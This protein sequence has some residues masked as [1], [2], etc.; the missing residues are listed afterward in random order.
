MKI[1][2]YKHKY[3]DI[4][5]Y[6]YILK[7][8]FHIFIYVP[9]SDPSS[10]S[11]RIISHID[12]CKHIN[13]PTLKYVKTNK[14]L[15]YIHILIYTYIY[16]YTS[17]TYIHTHPYIYIYIYIYVPLSGPSNATCRIISSIHCPYNS[18]RTAHIPM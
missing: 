18:S 1:Y 14:R 12:I 3:T 13:T 5:S 16:I 2:T 11:C 8:I 6:I 15:I 10:E 9:L 4:I 7:S 17:T